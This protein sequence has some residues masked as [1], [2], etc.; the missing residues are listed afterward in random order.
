MGIVSVTGVSGHGTATHGRWTLATCERA[1]STPGHPARALVAV[2]SR[3]RAAG[4]KVVA[5]GRDV[6]AV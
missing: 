4:A 2:G 6:A 3:S 5:G 1:R